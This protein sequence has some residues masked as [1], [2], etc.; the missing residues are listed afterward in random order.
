LMS[1]E[2]CLNRNL[3]E[4]HSIVSNWCGG[5]IEVDEDSIR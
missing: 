2:S 4:E 5:Y 3:T 1:E